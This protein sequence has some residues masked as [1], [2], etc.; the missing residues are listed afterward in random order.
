MMAT[1]KIWRFGV[2]VSA[3]TFITV[4]S[5]VQSAIKAHD[6]GIFYNFYCP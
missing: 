4:A 3:A 1:M 5:F 6:M 2:A